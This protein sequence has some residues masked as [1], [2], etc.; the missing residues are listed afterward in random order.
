MFGADT[1]GKGWDDTG[2]LC[3]IGI[4]PTIAMLSCP[5]ETLLAFLRHSRGEGGRGRRE[6]G[7]GEGGKG[8][9]IPCIIKKERKT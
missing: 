7:R 3:V 1:L 8:G 2:E 9:G 5:G 6:E 4:Q